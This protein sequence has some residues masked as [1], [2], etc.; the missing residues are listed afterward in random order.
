MRKVDILPLGRVRDSHLREL[1]DDYY[2]RCSGTLRV[3]EREARTLV[4][5]QAF[6]SAQSWVVVL[7]ERGTQ[8]SSREFAGRLAEWLRQRS[9]GICFVIGGA[10][11]VGDTLRA[12]SNVLLSFGRMTIAHQLMRVVLA[13]QLYRA[14]SIIQGTPY[15]R[16]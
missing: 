13:E 14:V 3:R 10:D 2:R 16:E 9:S 4:Q 5:L 12:R 1:C 11:G 15:H 7:D 8:W 6:I